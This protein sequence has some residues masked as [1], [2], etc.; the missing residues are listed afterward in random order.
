MSDTSSTVPVKERLLSLDFFRGFT[1][2]LL[3][4]E[5]THF[6]TG[7]VSLFPEGHTL[8]FLA[9]QFHHAQWEG[10]HFWD[11]VQPFFMFIVGVA[12][13][14]S[15]TRRKK[16]GAG[17]KE[18]TMHVLKRSFLLLLLG[19]G[20]Y[21]I[22]HG[23]IVFYFQ[24]VLAQ[25]S[26][27][28]LIAY[29]I[30]EK[31]VSFQ[32]V[33]S[34]GLLLLTEILYRSFPVDGFDQPFTPNRNFGTW[35]DMLY[36]GADLG[37]HWVSFNAIP[38]AAHTIWGVLAGKLLLSEKPAKEK[39]KILLIAGLAGVVIGY[40]LQPVTPIIKRI[41]T[42]S[43]VIVSGGWALLVMA[44]S[45][46]LIDVKRS[47]KWVIYFAVVGMNPLFIY[48]FAHVGGSEFIRNIIRPFSNALFDW[49][50]K[51]ASVII[52]NG[53]VW[54]LLWYITWWMY[55]KKLFIRI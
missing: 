32:I 44:F 5:F 29:L 11:L 1:M 13:P 38:T 31:K 53:I 10:L 37:G 25:L 12:M 20:L 21:C 14:F 48:L 36:G 39:I 23:K 17:E 26:V 18:L 47:Q 19:W 9:V 50:G 6:L 8:H 15:F 2:I 33:F 51:P 3:V 4:G 54:F 42:S 30:M 40:A 46:W 24:N 35:L 7:I 16:A 52:M 34:F 41:A 49:T 43:F 22:G 27:T 28:Y 55:K 45:Y